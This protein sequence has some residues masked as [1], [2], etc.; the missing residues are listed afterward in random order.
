V[1]CW[2][3]GGKRERAENPNSS[4]GDGD[5]G[6]PLWKTAVLSLSAVARETL[7]KE[8]RPLGPVAWISRG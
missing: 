1:L 4:C 6:K 3:M 2:R 8:K 7:C 5:C